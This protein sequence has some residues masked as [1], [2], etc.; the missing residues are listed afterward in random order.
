MCFYF[1]KTIAR[2]LLPIIAVLSAALYI[3][4][5]IFNNN[6]IAIIFFF[7][8]V[9]FTILS[10]W[11]Y[12]IKIYINDIGVRFIKRK[13][14]F[15]IEWSDI[16]N[17]SLVNNKKSSNFKSSIIFFESITSDNDFTYYD[18][19]N[20]KNYDSRFF[21]ALY[22]EK[23]IQEVKKYWDKPIESIYRIEIKK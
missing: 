12:S 6:S 19:Y 20:Y 16:K 2:V 9:Y 17:I 3:G 7:I 4:F 23:I 22:Q 1:T 18:T 14:S 11:S 13:H 15:E 8:A 21:G 10:I 5:F